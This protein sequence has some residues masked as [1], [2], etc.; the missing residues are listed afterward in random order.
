MTPERWRKVEDLYHAAAERD[1]TLRAAY[2][3]EACGSDDELR[4]EVERLLAA[5]EK[6]TGN[7]ESPILQAAARMFEET[8][9]E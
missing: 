1:V 8:P 9:F 2:L 5:G 4:R 7:L 3:H 6:P